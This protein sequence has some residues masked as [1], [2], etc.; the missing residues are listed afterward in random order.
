[1]AAPVAVK[2]ANTAYKAKRIVGKVLLYAVMI[3]VA[4]CLILPFYWSL[5]TSFRP[6][7]QIQEIPIKL[8]PYS[9]T[10]E[11]YK[12]FMAKS[13]IFLYF[14]NTFLV[15]AIIIVADLL[16]CSL[17]AY[18]LSR[19]EY[20]GK[21]VILKIFYASM[22]IPGIIS[23]I[24]QFLVVNTLGI[25]SNLLGIIV[26]AMISI[27]GVLFLRSFFLSTPKEI[28]EAARID[29]AG[30]FRIYFSLYMRMIMPGLVT[31]ALFT[32]NSNWN[33]YLWPSIIVGNNESQWLMAIALKEFTSIYSENYGAMMAGS[34]ITVIPSIL[35][36]LIGQRYF[37]EN[38]TFAG[39]K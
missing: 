34:I 28:A 18:S 9:F 26:P 8:Y 5:L 7:N 27:Y 20:K 3:F 25:G 33:S 12:M 35:I 39:I 2:T 16:T 23:L 30:E 36:F 22:M 32:F 1:M 19:L 31:L 6:T 14:G 38:L 10:L 11:H 13:N 24:P 21:A 17:A 4:V 15:I 29:G 37:L